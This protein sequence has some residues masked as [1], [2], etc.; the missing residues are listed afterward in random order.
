MNQHDLIERARSV[1]RPRVLSSYGAEAGGV[2]S[3]LV[4]D[5]GNV[6]TGVCIDVACG[7]GFCAEHAAVAAMITQG[8]SQVRKIVAV[9]TDGLVMPPCGRCRELI[10]Q[11]NDENRRTEVILPGDK[12]ARL[13]DLLPQHWCR[14]EDGQAS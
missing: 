12:V 11:I 9:G 6:Y 2:G 13:E 10:Y 5:K 8:E 4:T 1:L 7:L 14:L 3:A